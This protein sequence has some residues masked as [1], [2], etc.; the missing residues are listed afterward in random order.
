VNERNAMVV[1]SS[2]GQVAE[3]FRDPV[4]P[5]TMLRNQG[6]LER[7]TS[8]F[9][10]DRR[11]CVTSMDSDRGDN[12]PNAGG[13]GRAGHRGDV[14]DLVPRPAVASPWPAP[15]R[16]REVRRRLTCGAGGNRAGRIS[17]ALDSALEVEDLVVRRRL[18]VWRGY[19]ASPFSL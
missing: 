17:G 13:R 8:P 3:F 10:L 5:A 14:E 15:P 18:E 16:A 11:L 9:L 12:S 19:P 1:V 4:D 2:K 6:P 7:P